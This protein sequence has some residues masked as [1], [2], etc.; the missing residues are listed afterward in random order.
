MNLYD[1]VVSEI[2]RRHDGANQDE[3]EFERDEIAEILA[4]WGETVRNLGD[5]VYSYR[6]GRMLLPESI[7]STG[8]WVIEGRGKGRYALRRLARSPYIDFPEDLQAIDI[9]DATPDIILRFGAKDEQGLLARVRYN[10]LVDT[11]LRVTAYHLQ[12]HVRASVSDGSQVEIDDL[13]LG[14][15]KDGKQYV[16]PVEGKTAGESLGV[17]QVVSLNTFAKEKYPDLTLRP[18]AVK[19]WHDGTLFFAEFN[20]TLD[21]DEISVV[22]FRRYR[23]VREDQQARQQGPAL[24]GSSG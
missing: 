11:F 8:N 23:L 7:A 5:I 21:S 3:F 15:D 16:T 14:V 4:E 22:E 13:Y 1:R 6:S 10:R 2:F 12:G 20:N 18:I 9:L 24:G 17:I 19:E